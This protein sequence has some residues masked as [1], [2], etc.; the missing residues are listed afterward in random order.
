MPHELFETV[1]SDPP[2]VR[3][4][5]GTTTTAT[6]LTHALVIGLAMFMPM[7]PDEALPLPVPPTIMAFAV[8]PVRDVDI[9]LPSR[10]RRGPTARAA[11]GGVAVPIP[12]EPPRSIGADSGAASAFDSPGRTGPGAAQGIPS[13]GLM[14]GDGAVPPAPPPPPAAPIRLHS[15]IKP[16][17]RI[18]FVEPMY[19]QVARAARVQGVVILEA[20]I[21]V[22]GSVSDARI[23]R[24]IPLLDQAALAAVRQWRFVP[25]LLNGVPVPIIMTVTVNFSLAE[26]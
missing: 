22:D 14:A 25:T 17:Q 5:R 11:A 8:Q 3:C 6:I 24:S 7:V 10:A 23:L 21:G 20:T 9:E 18:G 19:P 15:G 1:A 12:V 2:R 4:S 13:V 26:R 16:P